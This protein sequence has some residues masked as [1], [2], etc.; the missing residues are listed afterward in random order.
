M[1]RLL[2]DQVGEKRF[3]NGVDHGVLF[4]AD[5]AGNYNEGHVWNGLTTVTESPSGAEQNKQY[6]DNMVY[7]AL[8][9]AEEFAGSIEAFT[10][11]D[12]FSECNGEAEPEPGVYLGQ[13]D[14][15]GF[16]FSWRTKVGNDLNANAGY[17]IHLVWGAQ[18][19]PSEKAHATVN[20]SPEAMSFSWDVTTTPVP[21]GTIGGTEYKPTASMVIDSTK[22]DADAL[23]ELEDTLYGTSG[24]D[25]VL[26]TPAEVIALFA[27]TN[28]E[29]RM[30]SANAPTYNSGTHIVTLPAVTGVQWKVNGVN[31]AS[32]AQPAMTVGQ[33]S[34]VTAHA[35][36]GY[37][38]TGDNDWTYDY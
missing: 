13:Q 15:R 10:Y 31:K 25:P 26:P 11:P 7:A 6:A 8:T 37:I 28:T 12:K 27:G 29:V 18:A 35:Q 38:L 32:G 2:W 4:L 21:V 17:K 16:G 5:N 1:A 9:S 23:A 19:A 33:T 22:V 24:E 14:R 36:S 20:D 34:V 30:T 3:E